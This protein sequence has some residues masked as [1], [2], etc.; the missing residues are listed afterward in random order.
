MRVLPTTASAVRRFRRR[1]GLSARAIAERLS[2]TTETVCLVLG[3]RPQDVSHATRLR[4]LEL[5]AQGISVPQIA[6]RTRLPRADVRDVIREGHPR[7]ASP[8]RRL[9]CAWCGVVDVG[10]VRDGEGDWCCAPGEGCAR[11]RT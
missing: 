4:V 2:L 6:A 7:P 8:R 10:R 5:H 1:N 9:K 11:R 3:L